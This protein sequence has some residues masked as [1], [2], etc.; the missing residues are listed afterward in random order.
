MENGKLMEYHGIDVPLVELMRFDNPK[1]LSGG[2]GLLSTLKDYFTF[3][4]M[5]A[6]G[7]SLNGV[8]IL[9]ESTVKMMHTP[10]LSAEQ[11]NSY[12]DPAEDPCSLEKHIHM[13]M[14]CAC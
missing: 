3:T 14:E 11:R 7:G 1:Y 10:Q 9:K 6:C 8:Q 2:A 5:L 13:D 12:N 4:Q